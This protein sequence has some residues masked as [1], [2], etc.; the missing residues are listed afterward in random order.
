[1]KKRFLCAL[2]ALVMVVGL[3]PVTAM[4]AS[5]AAM[6]TSDAGISIIKDFEGYSKYCTW[7]YSQWSIGYG[8]AC[9]GKNHPENPEYGDKGGH[10]ITEID[11]IAELTEELETVE[12]AVNTFATNNKLSLT[13]AKF[14][15]LVSFS[16][17]CGT[18]WMT[19]SGTFKSAVVNGTTGNDFLYAICLWANAGSVPSAGLLNRR[20][21]EANMYLNGVYSTTRPSNYTYVIYDGNGG[22][23]TDKMQGY[24]SSSAVAIKSTASLKDNVFMGWYTAEEGGEWVRS[25]SA[26]VAGKTLYAH[27]QAD[28][29]TYS[30]VEYKMSASS[31]TSLQPLA[32]PKADA[33]S[34]GAKLASSDTVTVVQDYVDANGAHWCRISGS[35]W[36]KVGTLVIEEEETTSSSSTATSQVVTVTNAYIN[37]RQQASAASTK[38]GTVN[39]GDKLTITQVTTAANGALWGK[40]DKGWVALMYTD[41]DA[42]K[43][44]AGEE[45]TEEGAVATAVV[46]CNTY[47][48]VR[49][50]AGMAYNTCGTLSNGT[51]VTIYEIKTV[52]GHDWG[53]ISSGWFCLD[54]AVL[55]M[56]GTSSDTDT[57]SDASTEKDE[58]AETVL[59]TGSVINAYVN[60]RNGAGVSYTQTRKLNYGE[61]VSLYEFKTVNGH[62]WGRISEKEWVCLDY[63]SYTKTATSTEDKTEEEEETAETASALFTGK[64]TTSK[65]GTIKVRS[66]ANTST[67][68]QV[69]SLNTGDAI[70]ILELTSGTAV[71]GNTVWG[72]V[73]ITVDEKAVE[74]WISMEYVTI[75]P[76]K[77]TVISN[78][79]NVRSAPGKDNESVDKLSKGTIVAIS[80]LAYV[81]ET[82]LW[83]YSDAF[84]G[85]MN[86]TSDYMQRTVASTN[87]STGS[88]D[89]ASS[90]SSTSGD[91]T[92]SG[93]NTSTGTDNTGILG[94]AIVNAGVQLQIRSGAGVNYGSVGAL[95]GGTA[96]NIYEYVV[97]NGAAWGRT[98][99][100]WIA[101]SYV[102]FTSTGSSANATIAN[103]YIGVNV[104][105][106]STTASALL[107][108]IMVNSRVQVL[109]TKTV[110]GQEW[111][112]V[113]LGWIYMDYV[114]MDSGDVDM[115]AIIN[116]TA[117][118]TSGTTTDSSTTTT[119]E[120]TALSS[121]AGKAKAATVIYDAAGSSN[122]I[123]SGASLAEGDAITVYELVTVTAADGTESYWASIDEGWILASNV[124]LNDIE[125]T[126]TITC[127][128]LNI[129][130]AAGADKKDIGDLYTGD[131]IEVT[132]LE[133]VNASIWGYVAEEKGWVNTASKYMTLGEVAI[134]TNTG[135]DTSTNTGTST[136]DTTTTGGVLYTGTVYGTSTGL[137]VRQSPSTS[138]AELGKLQN[139]T[140]VRIYE[141]AVAEYMA[142]G[143]CDSGWICLTYVNL[144]PNAGYVDARIVWVETLAIRAEASATSELVGN[145]SKCTI[146]DLIEIS[147]DWGRT[148]DGWIYLGTI[149]DSVCVLP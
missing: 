30:N 38:V 61:A 53:R 116:G 66:E 142:W 68:N 94:T 120:P 134:N 117:G 18:A 50:G 78:S 21:I 146:V 24:N 127:N 84:G 105:N 113:A 123:A 130:Q 49:K 26:S 10:Q 65:G 148:A 88:S 67:D 13:Q 86:I 54:Y 31:F 92:T 29:N 110:N 59:G 85:W 17:N 125:Q 111:G 60:V 75:D 14:D 102:M 35:G 4:T 149:G 80:D 47:V 63:V 70:E 136:S 91:S 132:K 16:Y 77:Y 15:A 9:D 40:F 100:G 141:V 12:K 93:S 108:K 11:A 44:A 19:G 43:V 55:T 71:N 103:T 37:V 41:Y 48:N 121:Y 137:R 131:V 140:T 98:D 22:T 112:R 124:V 81:N 79:L 34:H 101:L 28:Y 83:G 143:K 39:Y 64:V 27:W 87:N 62:E 46:S 144:D 69:G 128:K 96:V 2:L 20:L 114:L 104:R 109:E 119:T 118:S 7:D 107:T 133:I 90:D 145:Y 3:V 138:S 23:P 6:T 76:V 36:L 99:K 8:T 126:Y 147:G 135:T 58:N 139:N 95:A 45:T 129:R 72:K 32:S 106:S 1:M 51:K 73:E 115:D 122:Q 82:T 33:A 56:L 97:S 5:A 89:S 42:N 25:L 74:G 52:N 57:D